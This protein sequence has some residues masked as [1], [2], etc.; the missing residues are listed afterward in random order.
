M[1]KLSDQQITRYIY[2]S[3]QARMKQHPDIAEKSRQAIVGCASYETEKEALEARENMMKENPV[4]RP[5]VWAT[6]I[7]D[8]EAYLIGAPW[9]VCTDG[10]QQK[11]AE[12]IGM[13]GGYDCQ[14]LKHWIKG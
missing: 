2:E 14:D 12:F 13:V 9:I 4:P 6:I 11:A 5:I 10:E 1:D 3:A 8:E 7:K